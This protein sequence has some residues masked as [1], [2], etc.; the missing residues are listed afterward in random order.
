MIE[1]SRCLRVFPDFPEFAAAAKRGNFVPVCA[2][3]LADLLTPVSA[4]LRIAGRLR[5]PFL[6]ES[7]EGGEHN[8]R[9]YFMGGVAFILVEGDASGL[10][11]VDASGDREQIPG[12]P[13]AVLG[14]LQRCYKA[15]PVMG[16][17]PFTGGAVGYIGYDAIRWVEDIPTSNP[18]DGSMP[19]VNLAYYDSVL[20]FDHLR[21]RV[22]LVSNARVCEKATIEEVETA[23]EKAIDRLEYLSEVLDA[24]PGHAAPLDEVS[25]DERGLDALG[26][27][28]ESLSRQEFCAAVENAQDL[29]S[30]GDAFQVVLSRRLTCETDANPLSVY[31]ALRA[32]NPS[33][34]MFILD[35]G[36]A[37]VVGSSPEMLIKVSDGVVENRPIAGTRPRGDDGEADIALGKQLLADEKERAEHLMLVDLGRNDVGRVAEYGTVGVPEFMKI[38]RYSHVMHLV[39]SVKG[40]LR[41]EFG[42]IEA[43]FAAFPA[44]TVSGAPKIRAMEIIDDLE[45]LSRGVYAGAILYADF[46]GNLDSCITIRTIVMRDGRA[47]VQVGAGIVID[48]VSHREYDETNQKAAA[49]LQAL[50]WANRAE[51]SKS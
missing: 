19:W 46:A 45:P 43:L 20:A 34:Y 47:E 50:S 3:R 10:V 13:V 21:H 15:Q 30:A 23:Y 7:A 35:T 32:I 2:E 14:E 6:L 12:D 26:D 44:G 51:H 8:G 28:T 25:D 48:S 29:I 42:P 16:A 9:D 1:R 33:P 18:P 4:Y 31:R 40:T 41:P 37:H 38:E 22:V 11:K 24:V 17:P 5:R 49:A 36:Q 27:I 39:S